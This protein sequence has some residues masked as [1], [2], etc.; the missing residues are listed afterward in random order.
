MYEPDPSATLPD[1]TPPALGVEP[2]LGSPQLMRGWWKLVMQGA[3]IVL[4]ASVLSLIW[5]TG[6]QWD[7]TVDLPMYGVLIAALVAAMLT[8]TSRWAQV[9]LVPLTSWLLLGA[10]VWLMTKLVLLLT[11]NTNPQVLLREINESL[12]WLPT[13]LGWSLLVSANSYTKPTWPGAVVTLLTLTSVLGG[14]YW[15]Y[16][17]GVT[18]EMTASL[19]QLLLASL[20]AYLGVQYFTERMHQLRFHEGERKVLSRMAYHDLLTSLPNRRSL[21]DELARL[22][23]PGSPAFALLFIDVD[24]FKVVNDTMGHD[25]GDRLLQ[26]VSERLSAAAP[27]QAFR[28][29]GDEFVMVLPQ[30]GGEQASE[31]AR[32]LQ[33][34]IAERSDRELGLNI[35]LSIGISCFPDDGAAAHELLRHADS[36]MY[37]V[38]REGRGQIKPYQPEQDQATER[39]QHIAQAIGQGQ[40]PQQ[41]GFYLL[42]QPIFDLRTGRIV[43]A[44]ALLRWTHAELGQLSPAEFVPVAEQI[45][46]MPR[47]GLWVLEEACHEACRWP[48]GVRVSVNVSAYQLT[49]ADFA[50]QVRD[51]LARSGL[52]SAALEIEL[53]ETAQLYT[54]ERV[55]QNLA[56][57][58][59]LGVA[60]SI[61]D[62]GAGYA[63]L[64]RLRSLQLSGIK[65]DRSLTEH[66]PSGDEFSH[67]ITEAVSAL[68]YHYSLDLTAEGLE[69][70]EHVEVVYEMGCSLGQG[71][72]LAPPL[73]APELQAMFAQPPRRVA[74]AALKS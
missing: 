24:S 7:Q 55:E 19:S 16:H 8:L 34:D 35:S 63:N 46:Q 56:A 28:L 52:S 70:Q 32:Q 12:I 40:A 23:A 11:L 3:L 36:A 4:L 44:E 31:L 62:F 10:V 47:L 42:Y 41:D 67:L 20:L 5:S 54:D 25:Q 66:L 14:A 37:A 38:K 45:G 9:T 33:H 50:A 26:L 48:A 61:D 1:T 21:E 57:L 65:L 59:E 71:F 6:D 43:K 58:D 39:F 13:L 49:R 2:E 72:A 18:P 68:A 22:T 73:T 17:V 74:A 60:L 27:A 53:T 69:T 15:S 51:I 29:S 64:T 30:A